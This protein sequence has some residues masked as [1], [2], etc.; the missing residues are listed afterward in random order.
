MEDLLFPI[1]SIFKINIQDFFDNFYN[2][3]LTDNEILQVIYSVKCSIRNPKKKKILRKIEKNFYYFFVIDSW[4]Y[5]ITVFD[6]TIYVIKT[7]I[8]FY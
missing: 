5:F 4:N 3:L 8:M 1:F 6:L 2:I 7:Y